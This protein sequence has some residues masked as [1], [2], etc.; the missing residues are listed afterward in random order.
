[1]AIELPGWL[2]K[3]FNL[4]GLA[5]GAGWTN[6][7][8]DTAAGVGDIHRSHA[9]NMAPATADAQLHGQR[10]TAAVQGTAGDAMTTA[11]NHPQGPIS[12]LIDH[13][14]GALTIGFITGTVTPLMLRAYKL[15]KLVDGAVT[16]GELA[17]SAMVP[18][19]EIAWPEELAA[20]RV[21]QTAITNAATSVLMGGSPV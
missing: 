18:G 2:A 1:M 13:N 17:T 5:G 11:V 8:E 3:L 15:T 14:R 7:N 10:A 12:N 4:M 16:V 20:G 6:A 19:G 21:A 9:A